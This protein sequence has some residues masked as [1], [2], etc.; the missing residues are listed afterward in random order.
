MENMIKTGYT[1]GTGYDNTLSSSAAADERAE[2]GCFTQMLAEKYYLSPKEM[3]LTEYK[4]YF[5]DKINSLYTHPSQKKLNWFIDITDNAYRRMQIDPAYERRVLN[6][7]AQAKSADYGRCAPRF[8]L[9]HIDDTWEKCYGYTYGFQDDERARRVA[10][11]KRLKARLAKK[12][13]QK[14][15][16][17]EYLNK[18]A[19]AKRLQ[20]QLLNARITKQKLEHTCLLKSWNDDRKRAQASRAYEAN[21]LMLARRELQLA[22]QKP[23]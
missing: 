19:Q 14:K 22:S 4:L 1:A 15:L 16:L 6:F 7:L 11:K 3:S 5:H 17:K 12:E 20:E 9:I 8:G 18:K 2:S 21:L 10:A 23:Y 13:R